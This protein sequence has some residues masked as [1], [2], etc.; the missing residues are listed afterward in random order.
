MK[1]KESKFKNKAFIGRLIFFIVFAIIA[2]ILVIRLFPL[3]MN[4]S[5][6]TGRIEFKDQIREMGFGGVLLLFGLQLAQILLIILPGEPLEVLA[7]MCYGAWG[8]ALFILICVFI[9]TSGIYFLTAKLGKSFLYNFFSKEKIDKIENSK[10]LKKISTIE[11]VMIILFLIPG[12][13]KDLLTYIGALLPIKPIRFILIATLARFPSVISSTL[14]GDTLTRGNWHISIAIY[15][16]T[17]VI[18]GISI[19]FINKNNKKES[20]EMMDIFK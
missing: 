16:I 9:T 8:G 7:G 12:T 18:T 3:I 4:L 14:A 19:Y 17:F 5:T 10:L 11:T 2:T 20:Q 15:A 6:Q 1:N 13:P